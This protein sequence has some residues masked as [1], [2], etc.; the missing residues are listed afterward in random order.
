MQI[1]IA[2]AI[3]ASAVVQWHTVLSYYSLTVEYPNQAAYILAHRP[4]GIVTTA[5]WC[6]V[7]CAFAWGLAIWKARIG[8]RLDP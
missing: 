2:L 5:C 3:T 1:L 8:D 6:T 7:V 4:P